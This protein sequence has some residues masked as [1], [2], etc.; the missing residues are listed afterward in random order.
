MK[1][2]ANTL[3]PAPSQHSRIQKLLEFFP[4]MGKQSCTMLSYT[5]E[6]SVYKCLLGGLREFEPECPG[7][8]TYPSQ[9]LVILSANASSTPS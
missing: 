6:V 8:V 1:E 5:K 4:G 7:L 9:A 3:L 2:A